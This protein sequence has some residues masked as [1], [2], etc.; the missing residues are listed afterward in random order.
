MTLPR[1]E[2]T[3]HQKQQHHY[4]LQHEYKY[5][6][7][8]MGH[9]EYTEFKD[10]SKLRI[11]QCEDK[12]RCSLHSPAIPL[13]YSRTITLEV[14]NRL[15]DNNHFQ[16]HFTLGNGDTEK[17]S[18]PFLRH[19]SAINCQ[20]LRY[21]E[22]HLRVSTYT[23]ITSNKATVSDYWECHISVIIIQ[24]RPILLCLCDLWC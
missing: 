3:E 12:L 10:G 14:L 9:V 24:C 18:L 17:I 11:S 4:E 1:E 23:P 16:H 15:E 19:N 20:Y 6:K 22:L 8:S 7:I 13:W 2:M 5:I 21:D